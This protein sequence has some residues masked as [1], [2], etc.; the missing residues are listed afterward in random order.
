MADPYTNTTNTTNTT[1]TG[2]VP[3]TNTTTSNQNL[4]ET[5]SSTNWFAYLLGGAVIAVGIVALVFGMSDDVPAP[6]TS[7]ATETQPAGDTNNVTIEAPAAAPTAP[8]ADAPAAPTAT[9][10]DATAP[11]N[12]SPTNP[13]ADPAASAP[14]PDAAPA[15]PAPAGN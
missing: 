2:R 8:A 9:T 3:P 14:A 10:P 13:S 1:P 6:A 11:A 5:Q 12:P 15:A 4:R 7:T